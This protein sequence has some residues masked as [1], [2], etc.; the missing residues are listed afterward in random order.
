MKIQRKP[1]RKGRT[2]QLKNKIV[3]QIS[4]RAIAAGAT[5]NHERYVVVN[6]IRNVAYH[7]DPKTVAVNST[8]DAIIASALR[9]YNSDPEGEFQRAEPLLRRVLEASW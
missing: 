6:N 4:G 2:P 8:A 9:N 1:T 7:H 3:N 5:R